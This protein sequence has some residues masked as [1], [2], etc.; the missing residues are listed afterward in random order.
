MLP[1]RVMQGKAAFQ[2][3]SFP[4]ALT[5]AF[6]ETVAGNQREL[7]R[8]LRYCE[9]CSF[10]EEEAAEAARLIDA[11]PFSQGEAS[12]AESIVHFVMHF[13]IL[14]EDVVRTKFTSKKYL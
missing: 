14:L 10:M 9:Y 12:G 2:A 5:N 13:L 6:A 11:F 8:A 1:S 4:R 7:R 3:A